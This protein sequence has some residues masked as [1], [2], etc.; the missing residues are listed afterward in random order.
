MAHV[1]NP[2]YLGGWGRIAWTR[3]AEV[4]V[5]WDGA[6]ALQ[7]GW[8][9]ETL[10]QNKQN[11]TKTHKFLILHSVDQRSLTGLKPRHQQGCV[12][13][14][15]FQ[16]QYISLSFPASWGHLLSLLYD[17]FLQLPCQQGQGRYFAHYCLSAA[18]KESSLLRLGWAICII[19]D[20]FPNSRD[21]TLITPSAKFLWPCEVIYSQVLGIRIWISSGPIILPTTDAQ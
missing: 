13:C 6:T 9:S 14:W 18:R 3:E 12:P 2:S 15:R 16:G 7:L 4:A 1:C 11:K 21:V 10:S 20:T 19:Q 5:S 8:Q 17:P